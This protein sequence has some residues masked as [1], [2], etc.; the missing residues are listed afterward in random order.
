LLI[1][2]SSQKG[3]AIASAAQPMLTLVSFPS[4]RKVG[5][6]ASA[7]RHCVAKPPKGRADPRT[8]VYQLGLAAAQA[9][10]AR[11]SLAAV[12]RSPRFAV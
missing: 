8:R 9:G 11:G 5:A 10:L 3:T 12:L 7:L 1:P 6:N 4:G 2:R